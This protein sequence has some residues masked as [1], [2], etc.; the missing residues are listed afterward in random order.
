MDTRLQARLRD[1]LEAER[2]SLV[3]DLRAQGADPDSEKVDRIAVDQ[4]F[5]DSAQASAE[6]AQT[7]ARIAGARERLAEVDAA[8]ARMDEGTY[9]LCEVCGGVIPEARLEARPMSTRDVQHASA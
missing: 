9:G 8:L 4:N 5:A 3:A 2:A 7:L 6:R 1:E